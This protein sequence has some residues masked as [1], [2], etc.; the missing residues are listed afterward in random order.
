[1]LAAK[2]K[3]TWPDSGQFWSQA[4]FEVVFPFFQ[5]H[6]APL[7]FD[8]DR[9]AFLDGYVQAD[10]CLAV[11]G[12]RGLESQQV[13]LIRPATYR[14]DLFSDRPAER[15]RTPPNDEM[16]GKILQFEP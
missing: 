3:R 7:K 10:S 2:Q 16:A 12:Q 15:D 9:P 4:S 13:V 5:G 8:G 11:S 14:D 6:E 1:A